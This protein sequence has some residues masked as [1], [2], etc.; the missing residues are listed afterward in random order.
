MLFSDRMNMS[1]FEPPQPEPLHDPSQ[2]NPREHGKYHVK[3]MY[4]GTG[5][6]NFIAMLINL[7]HV[8]SLTS[9]MIFLLVCINNCV[10]QSS[11]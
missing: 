9:F 5:Q 2:Q 3:F 10:N 1:A 6:L 11:R 8:F 4:T 7:L